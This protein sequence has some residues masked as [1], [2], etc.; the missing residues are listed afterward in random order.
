M[1][2]L[3]S[4]KTAAL[5]VLIGAAF[6]VVVFAFGMSVGGQRV[7][8]KNDAARIEEAKRLAVDVA[9]KAEIAAEQSRFAARSNAKTQ[10]DQDAKIN[11]S[12][13]SLAATIDELR[14][15]RA[16]RMSAAAVGT[17]AAGP[18]GT[19]AGLFREDAEFLARTAT[20]DVNWRIRL[21]ACYAREDNLR[22]LLPH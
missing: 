4:I 11:A 10:G 8:R 12:N 7:Q 5:R 16:E 14:R 15:T 19:G 22:R 20:E 1:F 13:A 9:T 2:P 21:I 3:D 17:A 6:I 18:S